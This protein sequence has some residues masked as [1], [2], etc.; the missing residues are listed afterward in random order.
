[1]TASCSSIRLNSTRVRSRFPCNARFCAD[2]CEQNLAL[3]E[4]VSI[5]KVSS[6]ISWEIRSRTFSYE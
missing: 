4:A 1:M 6:S 3:P 2:T 5:L